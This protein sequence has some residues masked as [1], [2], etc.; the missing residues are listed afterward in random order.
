[1]LQAALQRRCREKDWRSESE[2]TSSTDGACIHL[3]IALV[4][5]GTVAAA[6][7]GMGLAEITQAAA[8]GGLLPIALLYLQVCVNWTWSAL[9]QYIHTYIFAAPYTCKL[10]GWVRVISTLY[11]IEAVVH[12]CMH[13][14]NGSHAYVA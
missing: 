8:I 3:Q 10:H 9:L 13:A 1:M 14:S 4:A 5:A 11:A 12:A 7:A 6:W 2:T